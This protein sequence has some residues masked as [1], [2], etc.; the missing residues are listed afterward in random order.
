MEDIKAKLCSHLELDV[1][2]AALPCKIKKRESPS[3]PFELLLSFLFLFHCVFIHWGSWVSL[4]LSQCLYQLFRSL[5]SSWACI[6]LP[7]QP[8]IKNYII[9]EH[10]IEH[11]GTKKGFAMTSHSRSPMSLSFLPFFACP[12]LHPGGHGGLQGAL[13]YSLSFYRVGSSNHALDQCPLSSALENEGFLLLPLNSTANL[14]L[15]PMGLFRRRAS[16]HVFAHLLALVFLTRPD[17]K[18]LGS[19]PALAKGLSQ[20]EY[21]QPSPGLLLKTELRQHVH[22]SAA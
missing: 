20:L 1:R 19:Q 18:S 12:A 10:H 5:Q 15:T 7:P 13:N 9:I 4:P 2:H 3:L 11:P 22:S 6:F 17:S 21:C 14:P 16:L 8:W